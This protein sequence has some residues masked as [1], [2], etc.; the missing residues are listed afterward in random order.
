MGDR[1]GGTDSVRQQLG[2]T[3]LLRSVPPEVLA[4][5]AGEVE[6]QSVRSGQL[7]CDEGAEGTSAYLVVSG[8][9]QAESRGRIIGEIG[10]GELIGEMSLLTGEPRTATVTAMR[11]SETLVLGADMFSTLLS[12]HPD[13]YQAVSRQLV[14]RLQRVLTT[15]IDVHRATVLTVIHDGSSAGRDAVEL[16]V[17]QLGTG[18]VLIGDEDG[19]D[20]VHLEMSHEIVVI[21]VEPGDDERRRW[22]LGQCDRA[23]LVVDAETRPHDARSLAREGRIE[24]V[25]VHPPSTSCPLGT[26][27][28]LDVL[29]PVAHHHVRQG[30]VG[31]LRR[32]ARSLR[33]EETVLVLSG[34]G[35]RGLAH[36][37]LWRA[38]Q[39]HEV[40]VDGIVGVSAGAVAG[41][42]IAM[43]HGHLEGGRLAKKLF[44]DGGS[45]IDLTIPTIALAS[46]ARMNERLKEL[47]GPT[48]RL[49]DLWLPT[50]FVSANLTTND[51]HVHH[52]GL[53]WRALRASTA[54]PG[55]F[56]PV[57]EPAGL[58]VDGGVVANLPVDLARRIHPGATIVASDVS[59]KM[60]LLPD[61]FPTEAEMSG[62]KAVRSRVRSHHRPPGMVRI[63]AQV[64]ALGGA[65]ST[66]SRGDLHLEFDLDDF[67]VFDFKRAQAIIEAGYH[68]SRTQVEAFARELAVVA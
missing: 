20:I 8:R 16:F 28:W 51:V 4:E 22:A 36:A 54:I 45:P 23:L 60:E 26:E 1:S 21:M 15:S 58:L 47:C 14:E 33:N 42:V 12:R 46:G 52:K 68:Q 5:L 9:F 17:A 65:G 63:L 30:S 64:T 3:Q 55:V 24:L 59:R 35:A 11:D 29:E 48:R 39:E 67:G 37:G 32:V 18:A 13:C 57:A 10:R 61:E 56:P 27:R 44:S 6:P 19:P 34:G 50:S 40:G 2:A 53:L 49:E 62:W 25:L 38:M 66:Q 41:A 31:D 43:G 7:L